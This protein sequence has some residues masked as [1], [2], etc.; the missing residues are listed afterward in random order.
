MRFSG[1]VVS[2]RLCGAEAEEGEQPCDTPVVRRFLGAAHSQCLERASLS[3]SVP[4]RTIFSLSQQ[5]PSRG[6]FMESR[7]DFA[8]RAYVRLTAARAGN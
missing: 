7:H 1:V 2:G 3:I 4:L 5:D 8:A 6:C